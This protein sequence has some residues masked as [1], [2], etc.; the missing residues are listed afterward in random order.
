MCSH[1]CYAIFL[2]T[3][4]QPAT[5]IVHKVRV[6][7]TRFGKNRFKDTKKCEITSRSQSSHHFELIS[8]ENLKTSSDYEVSM[9]AS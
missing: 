9:Q 3:I 6:L 8:T 7:N 2:S 1:L 5:G 4:S